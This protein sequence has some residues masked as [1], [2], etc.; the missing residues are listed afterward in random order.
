MF[1]IEYRDGLKATVAMT[2]GH[3]AEFGFAARLKSQA[4]PVATRYVLQR[5]APYAHHGLLLRATEK[6]IHTGNPSFR[7]ERTLLTTGVLES[8]MQSLTKGHRRLET[9]HLK[10]EY[11]AVTW[12]FA[13]GTPP[14]PRS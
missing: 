11:K 9:P 13:K 14:A 12:P 10:V 7:V 8:L 1:L 6:M 2:N 3:A 4:E 5:G